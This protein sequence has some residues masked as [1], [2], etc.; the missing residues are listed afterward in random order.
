MC[1][2][3]HCNI[4]KWSLTWQKKNSEVKRKPQHAIRVMPIIRSSPIWMLYSPHVAWH[5]QQGMDFISCLLG[6]GTTCLTYWKMMPPPCCLAM[7][8]Q[9]LLEHEVVGITVKDTSR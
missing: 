9:V 4:G 5:Y 7:H 6:D 1:Q 8:G 2:L 3:F